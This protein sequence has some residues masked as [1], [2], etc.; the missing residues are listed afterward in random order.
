MTVAK[1]IARAWT[2]PAFKQLLLEDPR[3]AL[4]ETGV[5]VPAD[6]NLKVVEN[7]A[8]LHHLVV[9]M[10]PGGDDALSEKDLDAV[11]G[12]FNCYTTYGTY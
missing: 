8:D 1:A 3:A 10:R 4:A 5:D 12:G 2:D 9:P 7:T 11:A 6:V